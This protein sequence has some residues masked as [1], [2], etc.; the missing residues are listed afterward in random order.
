MLE[1][2][3][4]TRTSTSSCKTCFLTVLVQ[5][6]LKEIFETDTDIALVL[7][8]VTGGELF[9]RY[10]HAVCCFFYSCRLWDA[11][12][13]LWWQV[14]CRCAQR[15]DA[16]K[17]WILICLILCYGT[18]STVAVTRGSKQCLIQYKLSS[19]SPLWTGETPCYPHRAI[20]LW[21]EWV[22]G[23]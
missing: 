5:I 15:W 11:D 4:C 22:L 14:I 17:T 20:S 21:V 6:Q 1:A 3:R 18:R 19:G 10:T 2:D 9:D 12:T 23:N 13:N 16:K 7:E 8:L